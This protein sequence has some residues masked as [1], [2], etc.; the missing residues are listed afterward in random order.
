MAMRCRQP[1][2]HLRAVGF[3]SVMFCDAAGVAG[4]LKHQRGDNE[5]MLEIIYTKREFNKLFF[6]GDIAKKRTMSIVS[7]RGKK[8]Q[9]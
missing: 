5:Q 4:T 2:E 7:F 1:E 9:I 6:S 3:C 8:E